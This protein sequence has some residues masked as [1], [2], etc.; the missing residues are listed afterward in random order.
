MAEFRVVAEGLR[1]PEGPVALEDGSVLVVEIRGGALTRVRPDG[2]TEV[3]ADCGGGPN[4]AA[5]GPDG[6]V[7]VCNNGGFRWVRSGERTV[8]GTQPDDY[9]GGRIQRV[10]LDG[11]V[12]DLYT[13][14]DGHGL[15]GP[16]DLVFDEHGGFYFTDLGKIRG[17]EMRLG[18]LYYAAPDGSRIDELVFPLMQPNG[19]GLSPDGDRLHVAETGPGRVWSWPVREPGRLG[20]AELLHGFGGD[21]RLDSLAV[22]SAGNVCVATLNTGAISVLSPGGELLDVVR[23]PRHDPYVTNICFGGP[24]L[25]TA[26][27]TASTDG[28]LYATEWPRPGLATHFTA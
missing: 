16:N 3:V 25:R 5:I 24:D 22:D 12:T 14:V 18:G 15:V 6:A 17:R 27:I 11:A 8:P 28:V 4:G 7:Y 23:P 1:F 2:T 13:T 26:Y 19:V 9:I 21:Q 10:T 20:E